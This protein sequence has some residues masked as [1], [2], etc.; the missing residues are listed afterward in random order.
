VQASGILQAV[1]AGIGITLLATLIPAWRATR[2]APLAALQS[3]TASG[4]EGN[5]ARRALI[6]FVLILFLA[7][8]LVLDPPARTSLSPPLDVALTGLLVGTCL[9][10]L[11]LLLPLL[12][13]LTSSGFR[14]LGRF[15]SAVPRLTADNLLRARSRVLLTILT[16]AI[17]LLTI[18]SVTGITT[19]SFQ[20]VTTQIVAQYDIEWIVAPVPGVE[21]GVAVSWGIL[22][23]WDLATWVLSPEYLADL[24]ALVK[25]R[26]L[27]VHVPQVE[28]P[29]LAIMPGLPVFVGDPAEL[30]Q[31]GLFTFTEGD[32]ATA[33]PIMES[34]CGLLLMPRMAHKHKAGLYD[35]ITL[36]GIEGPV[37][38]TVAGLG[39][40]S[41]M[42]TSILSVA[43]GPA[44]GLEANHYFAVIVL[45]QPGVD[46]TALY[47]DLKSLLDKHPGHSLI[48]VDPFFDNV[49]D[50]VESLQVLLNSMLLLAILAATLGVVNT[51]LISVSERRREL[52]LLRAVGASRR[53][54]TAIVIGEAAL[55]GLLGGVIG[56]L[57]GIGLTAIFIA[58]NGGNM[59][60][61]QDLPLW[62]STWTS[63][64]P[65]LLN[66][67]LGLLTAPFLCA[68]AAWLPAR[69]ILQGSI[70]EAIA[71][72]Q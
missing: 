12:V 30:S 52:G 32:W 59:W 42:G 5:Y 16:L 63:I 46:R 18:T 49:A 11:I 25:E 70:I 3:R 2:T 19:F 53:Q 64:R 61:F 31:S 9:I 20:V 48:H 54:V 41:F 14:W 69:Q 50:M 29:E 72:Q 51:T 35:K 37:E 45:P 67:S 13:A 1:G 38:C 62:A 4:L 15:S 8:Y 65:A 34:G 66:G 17:A 22:S 56:L 47:A 23:K 21:D 27:L 10:G 44:F 28:I 58:V 26:A 71:R 36:Q 57:A 39:T 68:G 7:V 43:A 60:G 24:S 55:I 6:G 33:Q 40:S